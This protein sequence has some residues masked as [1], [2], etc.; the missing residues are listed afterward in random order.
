MFCRGFYLKSVGEKPAKNFPFYH[1]NQPNSR[2]FI[3]QKYFKQDILTAPHLIFF[4]KSP[5]ENQGIRVTLYT[6]RY[7]KDNPLY[8]IGG[9]IDPGLCRFLGSIWW[10]Q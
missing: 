1:R 3:I 7:N 10:R 2:S 4:C 9:N 8:V 5:N 6:N